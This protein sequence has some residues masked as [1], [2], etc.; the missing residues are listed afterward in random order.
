MLLSKTDLCVLAEE[1][2]YNDDSLV[3]DQNWRYA[4]AHFSTLGHY[5]IDVQTTQLSFRGRPSKPIN[6][7]SNTRST[8]QHQNDDRSQDLS[9]SQ[10]LST[11]RASIFFPN[12]N[13]KK[14]KNLRHFVV[15][16]MK[17]LKNL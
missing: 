9:T 2:P 5:G 7:G 1:L 8:T 13:L 3:V 6:R 11:E 4:D 10:E 17:H 12:S 16:L 14:N 15:V